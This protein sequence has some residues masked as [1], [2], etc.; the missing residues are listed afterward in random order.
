LRTIPDALLVPS[1]AVVKC[2]Q[3]TCVF[4]AGTDGKAELRPVKTGKNL[5]TR[6]LILAGLSPGDAVVVEGQN[7]LK[8]ASPLKVVG[9]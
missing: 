2:P 4:L 8:P 9:R 3:G 5:E 6:T 1:E 7:K